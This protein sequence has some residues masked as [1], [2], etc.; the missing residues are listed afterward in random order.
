MPSFRGQMDRPKRKIFIQVPI[1]DRT[2]LLKKNIVTKWYSF[3]C[4]VHCFLAKQN[5]IGNI[6]W[7]KRVKREFNETKIFKDQEK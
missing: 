5:C 7:Q 4:S 1:F 2:K 3:D 6:Q